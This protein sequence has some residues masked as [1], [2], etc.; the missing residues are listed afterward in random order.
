MRDLCNKAGEYRKQIVKRL[1][2]GA[3]A[4]RRLLESHIAGNLR[5]DRSEKM[6]V[7]LLKAH[8]SV[9]S[10][11]ES[12]KFSRADRMGYDLRVE[13]NNGNWLD[14]DIK[15]SSDGVLAGQAGRESF[16]RRKS[17]SHSFAVSDNGNRFAAYKLSE[18]LQVHPEDRKGSDGLHNRERINAL[19]NTRLI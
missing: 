15:A 14:L 8:P 12:G 17:L 9:K 19:L 2:R 18:F 5:G 4:L 16:R 3:P 11:I 7:T 1:H 10:V 6:A 13:L